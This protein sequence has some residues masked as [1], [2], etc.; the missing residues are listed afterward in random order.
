MNNNEEIIVRPT[1]V[2]ACS[3]IITLIIAA[4][5]FIFL[6]WSIAPLFILAGIV[7]AAI[8]LYRYALIR[9]TNF[10][11][12]PEYIRI[13]SGLLFKRTDQVEM[14][15]VKDYIITRSLFHQLFKMMDLTL[16]TTDPE[17]PVV[18]IRGI[19]ET[20]LVDL[21]RD[22]VQEA[23]KVNKVVELS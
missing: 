11:I 4:L 17:N 13:R 7:F 8:G 18:Y 16:K 2:Y 6:A 23:R 10:T 15:R 19:P 20:D 3:K 1:S 5:A 14:Y 21:I 22:R 9:N 12:E